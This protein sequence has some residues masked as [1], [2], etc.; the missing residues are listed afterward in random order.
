MDHWFLSQCSSTEHSMYAIQIYKG[1]WL[2]GW[3]FYW[4]TI[5]FVHMSH[6]I[7]SDFENL[8]Y[9]N[10]MT[11]WGNM[12][13]RSPYWWSSHWLEWHSRISSI[14]IQPRSSIPTSIR[15]LHHPVIGKW[16]NRQPIS[17]IHNSDNSTLAER[18]HFAV[19]IYG[20]NSWTYAI[21]TGG[22]LWL[23]CSNRLW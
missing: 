3:V 12:R 13:F 21:P 14:A 4:N 5:T 18:C 10:L 6:E 9:A 2:L 17:D 16:L 22:L 11:Q 15:N 20:L 19:T 1:I 7:R 23:L 8:N